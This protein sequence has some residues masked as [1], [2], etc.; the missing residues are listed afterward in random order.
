MNIVQRY[1]HGHVLMRM[2]GDVC[3]I[4]VSSGLNLVVNINVAYSTGMY[5]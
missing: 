2:A 3:V 1:I 4:F 5:I